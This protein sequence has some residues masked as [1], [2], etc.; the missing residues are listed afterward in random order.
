MAK[1]TEFKDS[2]KA[3]IFVRDRATCCFS[4]KSL[5]ILDYGASPTYEIDWADHIK[6]ASKGGEST[7][8]NGLC[9]SYLFNFKKQAN[10]HDNIIFF[11]NGLPTADFYYYF[12]ELPEDIAKNLA[13]FSNLHSSDWYFNRGLFRF[14]NGVGRMVYPKD[15]NEKKYLRDYKYY[16]KSALKIFSK[17]RA[18]VSRENV[19]SLKQRGIINSPL[20]TEQKILCNTAKCDNESEI[21]KNMR[22]LAPY[23][24]NG[25]NCIDQMSEVNN[26]K[27]LQKIK[28]FS[29]ETNIPFRLKKII[30]RN[31]SSISILF[32]K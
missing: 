6:P 21:I 5:W 18:L 22:K 15:D 2:T 23:Y 12:E 3:E 1:R 4:G 30:R 31:I 9:T 14:I 29:K 7:V 16:A 32:E 26:Q 19:P 20:N 10:S 25:C 17:W 28:Q 13:R 8:E 27:D 24:K 11:E